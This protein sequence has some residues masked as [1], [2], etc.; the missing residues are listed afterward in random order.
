MYHIDRHHIRAYLFF[1]IIS[2]FIVG[3]L[4]YLF[5]PSTDRLASNALEEENMPVISEEVPYLS[6]EISPDAIAARRMKLT[7]LLLKQQ[8]A[9]AQLEAVEQKD[10]QYRS[11]VSRIEKKIENLE[12]MIKKLS[13]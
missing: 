6:Q 2:I 3:I 1:L 7:T 9:L 4:V 5:T 8:A 10:D 12:S 11:E 13:Q